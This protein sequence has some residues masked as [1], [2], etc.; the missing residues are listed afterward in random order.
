MSRRPAPARSKASA[1]ASGTAALVLAATLLTG[2]CSGARAAAPQC[3]D[4]RR[5]AIVAQSVLTAAYVPCLTPLPP[6]WSA[7]GFNVRT[8]TTRFSLLSDRADG[9]EVD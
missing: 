5:L 3:Q 2:G 6:G 7:T 4:A 1:G 9:R 8:G